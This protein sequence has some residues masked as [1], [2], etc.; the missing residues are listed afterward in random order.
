MPEVVESALA[1]AAKPG[2]LLVTTGEL[3]AELAELAL[4]ATGISKDAGLIELS[5]ET[6][7]YAPKS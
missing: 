5:E 6:D 3:A 1:C 2:S 7:M 4:L